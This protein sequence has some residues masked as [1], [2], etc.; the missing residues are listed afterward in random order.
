M[1]KNFEPHV[2]EE[3]AAA[4]AALKDEFSKYDSFIFTDYRGMTVEQMNGIRRNL[5]GQSNNY[6]VVK[7]NLARVAFSE[8]GATVDDSLLKGPTGVVLVKGDTVNTAAKVVFDSKAD[9]APVEVKGGIVDGKPMDAAT[10]EEYS[11]LPG[12][13]ELLSMLLATMMA[14]VQK[15]AATLLA[16]QKKLESAAP[17]AAPAAPAA[18]PAS[19]AAPAA[20]AAN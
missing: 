2:S 7:N 4:V 8:M 20:P 19:G 13:N 10:L 5:L 6:R 18:A 9:G 3:K 1:S 17:A 15:L 14:P 12:K 11:K 16:Y